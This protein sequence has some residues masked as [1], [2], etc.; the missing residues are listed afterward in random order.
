[1]NRIRSRLINTLVL[2]LTLQSEMFLTL[3]SVESLSSFKHPPCLYSFLRL[4]MAFLP[5]FSL[6]TTC[7]LK[8]LPNRENNRHL[9]FMGES[10]GL[11]VRVVGA[12]ASHCDSSSYRFHPAN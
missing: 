8:V 9:V 11:S 12:A 4:L 6:T 10:V 2:L 3:D 5:G 7:F 1:M